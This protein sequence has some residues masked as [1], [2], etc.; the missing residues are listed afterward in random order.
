VDTA[1]YYVALLMLSFT[2]GVFLFWFS[3]HPFVGFWRRVGAVPT[4]VIHYALLVLLAAL[5][6]QIRAPLLCVEFGTQPVLVGLGATLLAMAGL[7]RARIAK[8]LG[9]ARVLTGL[10]ELAPQTYP[11]RLATEGLY[12]RVRHPRYLQLLLALVGYA[13]FANYLAT[14]V[15]TLLACVWVRLVV[16]VEERELRERFGEEYARYCERVP[17]FIPTIPTHKSH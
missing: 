12:S 7:L 3:I 8:R 1:R 2:P 10:P 11:S 17:R 16:P 15:V 4:L 6:F 5:V 13:L 9:G 14:Y